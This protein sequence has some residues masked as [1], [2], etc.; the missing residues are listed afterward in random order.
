MALLFYK[1]V[2]WH[3]LL[4][5]IFTAVVALVDFGGHFMDSDTVGDDVYRDWRSLVITFMDWLW[6]IFP[7]MLATYGVPLIPGDFPNF[8]FSMEDSSYHL[9]NA[10]ITTRTAY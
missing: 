9:S 1:F 10:N 6:Q 7:I 3:V 5:C 2:P 8:G 4:T